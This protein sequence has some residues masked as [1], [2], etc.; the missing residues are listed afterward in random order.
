MWASGAKRR[1]RSEGQHALSEPGP[2]QVGPTRVG[3]Y[4]KFQKLAKTYKFKIDPL[5][6]YK[7]NK[8]LHDAILKY[9]E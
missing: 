1:P 6:C 5:P 2:Q 7:N 9:S 4:P 8:I 3:I